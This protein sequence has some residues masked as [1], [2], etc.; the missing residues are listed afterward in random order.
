VLSVAVPA[1]KVPSL[2]DTE[3]EI[4]RAFALIEL[5]RCV[6][7]VLGNSGEQ[8]L[9]GVSWVWPKERSVRVNMATFPEVLVMHAKKFQLVNWVPTKLDVPAILPPDDT[10][11]LDTSRAWPPAG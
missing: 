8:R 9:E 1:I 2:D 10:L 11:T 4:R 5:T 7:D 3:G 6:G